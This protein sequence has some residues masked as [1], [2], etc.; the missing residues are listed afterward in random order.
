[1]SRQ[2]LS[3]ISVLIKKNMKLLLRAR[4]SVLIIILGPLLLIFLAGLAFDNTNMYSVK[5]GTF[6]E[7]YNSL[8][9]SFIERLARADFQMTRYSDK[10]E[11]VRAIKEGSIHACLVFSPQFTLNKNAN[12]EITF[13]IDYSKLNLVW[14]LLSVMTQQIEARSQEISKNL[15]AQIIAAIESTKK[16][17]IEYEHNLPEIITANDQASRLLSDISVNLE[18][19]DLHIDPNEL[20]L[21]ELANSKDR[22][23]HWVDN[24]LEIG[25]S[26]LTKSRSLLSVADT[27]IKTGDASENVKTAFRDRLKDI[28]QDM[29]VLQERFHST[30]EIAAEEFSAYTEMINGIT[31]KITQLKSKLL[32]AGAARDGS[33][34]HT[35]RIKEL[36][37]SS[38]LQLIALQ[39]LFQQVIPVLEGIQ[40]TDTETIVSP[41]VTTIQPVVAER[42]Y[43][44]YL[45]PTLVVLVVLFTSMLVAPLLLILEKNSPAYLRNFLTPTS[46][47]VHIV[48]TFVTCFVLLFAQLLIILVIAALFFTSPVLSNVV[49][50]LTASVF[51]ITCFILMSMILGYF[52]DSEAT[53]NLAAVSLSTVFLFLSNTIVPLE[54]MPPLVASLMA[55]NPFVLGAEMLR[56]TIIFQFSLVQITTELFILGVYSLFFVGVIIFLHRRLKHAFVRTVLSRFLHKKEL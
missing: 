7:K 13:H 33:L 24:S 37:D 49:T 52:F 48:A 28:L 50:T 23:K 42:S 47:A 4:A 1:M 26:A 10:G 12:N 17:L 6:S 20:G 39:K 15:T 38:L 51:L 56:K 3:Q 30:K 22:I 18:E 43:L 53:A 21:T 29:G 35:S 11:C 41:I 40:V 14:T 25:D 2:T 31:G 44:N 9:E 8:S 46:D 55:F 19:L 54:S 45:F 34:Q 16:S 27:V 36:L 5:I 32:A